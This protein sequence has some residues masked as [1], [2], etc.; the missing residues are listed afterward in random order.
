MLFQDFTFVWLHHRLNQ[1]QFSRTILTG[2]TDKYD[3]WV[4]LCLVADKD[5]CFFSTTDWDQEVTKGNLF[6]SYCAPYTEVQCKTGGG[7]NAL[8]FHVVFSCF[9]VIFQR[10]TSLCYNIKA[11]L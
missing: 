6:D 1:E 7:N 5:N 10:N 8:D 11:I 9:L 3:E 4:L 2:K